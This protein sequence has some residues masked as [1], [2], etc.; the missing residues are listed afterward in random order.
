MFHLPSKKYNWQRI[1]SGALSLGLGNGKEG[2][3][4]YPS[5]FIAREMAEDEEVLRGFLQRECW[6]GK[7]PQTT[8]IDVYCDLLSNPD[9]NGCFF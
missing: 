1:R 9:Q 7:L 3:A 8:H 6:L 4:T 2:I 5:L